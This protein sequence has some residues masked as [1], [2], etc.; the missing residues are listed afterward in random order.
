MSMM[1]DAHKDLLPPK[2]D[3]LLNDARLARLFSEDGRH[4][5]LQLWVLQIKFEQSIENRVVYGRL[6]PYGHSSDRWFASDDDNF[7]T[8]GH[9]EAQVVRLSLYVKSVRCEELLR[10][11]SAGETI[12][13]ISE[14]L[15]LGLSTQLKARF[16]ATAL[17]TDKLVYRPVAYLL[18]RDAF[19]RHSPSSPHGGAGALS[20]SI[21]RTDKGELFRLGQDYDTALTEA[22]VKQLNADT[23]LD[24]AGIDTAR[25]GDLELMVFPALDDRERPLLSVT[26]ADSP[27]ALVARF[28]PMQVPHFRGFQFRLTI[29]ND[30]QIAYSGIATAERDAGGLFQ[31][32]FELSEQQRARTDRTEIEIFGFEDHSEQG[33]LCCRWRVG[34]VR[35]IHI[36]GHVVGHDLSP[37][38]FDWLEKATRPSL[39]PRVKAALT[40][41]RGNLGFSSRIGGREADPWVPANR[42]LAFLFSRLHPPKSEGR[43]FLHRHQDGGESRLQFVEWF[44]KLLTQYH[45]HQIVVFDPYFEDA[46]LGLLLLC[47]APSADCIVF[48][49]LPK[50]PKAEDA[51]SGLPNE[52]TPSGIDNL[53]ANCA[54]NHSRLQQ[55]RLRIFGLKYGRL[56]DRYIL[57][58]A[59]DGLPVAGFNLS[60]S[61]QKAAENYPLLVT[62]IPADVLLK[63]E[64][65][66]LGLLR[67]A[68]ASDPKGEAANPSIQLLFDSTASA[69]PP[70]H[71]EPLRFLENVCAG[72]ALSVW[73][74]ETSLRG[75]SGDPLKER[76]AALGLLV[77]DTLS[78]P[79]T[80][81]LQNY[82]DR[83]TGDFADFN[84][85]WEVL[86]D[87]LAH[88]HAENYGVRELGSDGVFLEFL[89]RFLQASF[90]REHDDTAKE[91]A[92]IRAQLFR[93]PV[94]T[95]LHS[96]YRPDHLFHATKYVGLNWSE[97]FA[98]R[99]LWRY[100]PDT[101]LAVAEAQTETVPMEPQGRDAVRLCLLTQI[102]SEISLSIQFDLG[103]DQRDRLIRSRNGLLKWMGL[104]ALERQLERPEGFTAVLTQVAAFPYPEQVQV[105]GWMIQRAAQ[106]PQ[107]VEIYN[108]LMA[109]LHG[110]LPTPI[111][112]DDLKRVVNSMRGHMRQLTW[113]EPWLFRDVVF[114]LLQNDRANIGD[115]CDIWVHELAACCSR[116][117][118]INS[119]CLTELARVR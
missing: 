103:A 38:K 86:G 116:N 67:E 24:F 111:P 106:K 33:T 36:Q 54:H 7:Q 6:L 98:I 93:D 85:A 22:T 80:A 92:V 56:H 94:E 23:G 102:I 68:M 91:L 74:G 118:N 29:A 105:L 31:C 55:I 107:R 66:T 42:D 114:P 15:N 11:F 84:A 112:A 50:P 1:K 34:Y 96:S 28:N 99:F 73:T 30:D 8:F 37:V 90:N 78:L 95:L 83:R 109:A 57:V 58:I 65:Y 53:L 79:E 40:S 2:L 72:D 63:V 51:S 87:L 47:A 35:E 48:R 89:A 104:N 26:W 117:C 75:L 13:A 77:G 5:A 110:A 70:R 19:N 108:G 71:Y 44:R 17:P 64:Q 76:M 81:G 82:L 52:S 16:G 60:N 12:T 27:L 18:N 69:T 41:N 62:P 46:G 4:C 100:A 3:D 61:F 25:F 39:S 9:V 101:L 14:G 113:A 119:G 88:S 97:F 10:Q 115:A 49:S 45:Q 59:S 32:K 21:T 20:A 43:F